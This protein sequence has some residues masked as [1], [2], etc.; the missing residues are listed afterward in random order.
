MPGNSWHQSGNNGHP[1]FKVVSD[2][3]RGYTVFLA[4]ATRRKRSARSQFQT[5]LTMTTYPTLILIA[6][7]LDTAAAKAAGM[8]LNEPCDSIGWPF[9][10][11]LSIGLLL[12]LLSIYLFSKAIKSCMSK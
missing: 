7:A 6:L 9:Y 10:V 12:L 2:G 5:R 3:R 1:V 11:F 4:K 8:A